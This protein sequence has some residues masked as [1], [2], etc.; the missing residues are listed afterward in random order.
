MCCNFLARIT[1]GRGLE[2]QDEIRDGPCLLLEFS[3]DL[4][5]PFLMLSVSNDD[6]FE[7]QTHSLTCF[8][9]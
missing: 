8:L 4:K 7:L 5:G 1:L 6:F 9:D 3:S 2:E